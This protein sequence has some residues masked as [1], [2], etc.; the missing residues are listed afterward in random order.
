MI[1]VAILFFPSLVLE[2]SVKNAKL[3]PLACCRCVLATSAKQ[4]TVDLVDVSSVSKTNK[5]SLA[6]VYC[7]AKYTLFWE[8][9]C[10]FHKFSLGIFSKQAHL[11]E[12]LLVL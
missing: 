2:A 4:V 8:R 10:H 7:F 9:F 6:H 1:L 5:T 11:M 3:M 12:A